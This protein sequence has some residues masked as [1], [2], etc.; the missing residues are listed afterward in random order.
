M[1]F[2]NY[3]KLRKLSRDK[4]RIISFNSLI[5]NSTFQQVNSV[6][7]NNIFPG[8]SICVK[9]LFNCRD[10]MPTLSSLKIAKWLQNAWRMVEELTFS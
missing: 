6:V 7:H 4:F 9:F 3:T 8:W 2:G 10:F 5:R 1:D